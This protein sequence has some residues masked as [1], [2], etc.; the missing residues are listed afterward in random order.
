MLGKLWEMFIVGEVARQIASSTARADLFHYR[1]KNQREIDLIVQRPD[2]G[3][4]AVEI[5]ATVSPTSDDLRHAAW[6]RDRLDRSDPGSFLGGV[7]VHMGTQSGKVGDRLHL[8]PA[9]ALWTPS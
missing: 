1:T 7:L 6:L 2:G 4:V 8:R 3:I 9:S 5:K